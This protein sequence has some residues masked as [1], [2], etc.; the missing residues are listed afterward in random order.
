[1]RARFQHLAGHDARALQR[2]GWFVTPFGLVL[3]LSGFS[4]V[5]RDVQ[6]RALFLVLSTLSFSIFY[7][8]KMR[9]WNDYFFAARRFVPV[10]LPCG[11]AF[12]AVALFALGAKR[13]SRR[14][15]AV[16]LT[17]A[18]ATLFLRDARVVARHLSR[19][20]GPEDIVVF[21]QRESIHLLSLPLWS[22][23][24]I[25][26]LELA[27]WNPDPDRLG[28]LIAHWRKTYKNIYFAYTYR[29]EKGLCGVFLQKV[30][31]EFFPT[32]EWERSYVTPPRRAEGRSFRFSIARVVFPEQL[33]I[34]ALTE[35]D[36][37]GSDDFQVSGFFEKEGGGER[38]YRWTGSCGAIY[39]P[40]VRSGDTLVLTA[41]AGHRPPSNPA[42]VELDIFE[43]TLGHRLIGAEWTAQEIP[44]PDRLPAGPPILRL[45]VPTWRPADV[46]KASTDVRDLGIMVDRVS[47]RRGGSPSKD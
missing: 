44:L 19:L 17:L 11:L 41:S 23:H 14:A 32:L 26:V 45:R 10:I 36:I 33:S 5:L 6:R 46:L 24:G 18:I 47:I 39:L 21:E 8:Y 7:F 15:L 42:L 12:M 35:I 2:F 28:H 31:D 25:N 34:P 38:T 20:F 9:V 37:G 22:I 4:I 13:G 29:A 30:R 16:L 3:I 40:A 27:R 1:L 43:D